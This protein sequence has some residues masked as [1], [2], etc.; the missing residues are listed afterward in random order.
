MDDIRIGKTWT[1][2]TGGPEA[3]TPPVANTNVIYS[4]NVT[5]T[6]SAR[7][8]DGTAPGYRWQKNGVNLSDA[9]N[10]SGSGTNALTITGVGASDAATYSVIITNTMGKITNSSVV[11]VLNPYIVLQPTNYTAVVGFSAAFNVAAIGTPTLTYQWQRDGTDLVEG[12]NISGSKSASLNISPVGLGDAASY[13]CIVPPTRPSLPIPPISIRI[14]AAPRL[15][16]R[17]P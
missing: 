17:R 9:G 8:G 14:T 3:Q 13:S 2:I 15:S 16:P 10:I 5:L 12:G 11:N 6:V 4:S 7:S 1:F